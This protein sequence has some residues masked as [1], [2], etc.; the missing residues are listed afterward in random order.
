LE[1]ASLIL[2]PSTL[3]AVCPPAYWRKAVGIDMVGINRLPL[4]TRR[5]CVIEDS[6]FTTKATKVQK[7]QSVWGEFLN[8]LLVSF[9]VFCGEPLIPFMHPPQL[10]IVY[11][12]ICF[13]SS[14]SNWDRSSRT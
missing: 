1:S 7:T 9:C 10:S 3:I 14:S 5:V 12:T 6:G 11:S 8:V 2:S 13:S 4:I